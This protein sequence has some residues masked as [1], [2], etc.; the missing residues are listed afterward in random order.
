MIPEMQYYDEC[1]CKWIDLTLKLREKPKPWERKAGFTLAESERNNQFIRLNAWI[2]EFY[3][4]AKTK[5]E[6][7]LHNVAFVFYVP[8]EIWLKLEKGIEDGT[9]IL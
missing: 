4:Q 8:K 5:I 7:E 1:Q 9:I 3:P 6:I 2:E